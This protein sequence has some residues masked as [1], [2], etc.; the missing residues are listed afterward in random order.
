MIPPRVRAQ[1]GLDPST[2]Q[3]SDGQARE[4]QALDE[5]LSWDELVE[6]LAL[7]QAGELSD[8]LHELALAYLERNLPGAQVAELLLWP[9]QWFG[10]RWYEE[11]A[12]APEELAS[13]LLERCGR[14]LPGAPSD[15]EDEG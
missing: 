10:N 15:E 1:L 13:H 14:D 12:L 7:V 9:G 11:I 6:V 8:E 2:P 5:A 4:A 3:R